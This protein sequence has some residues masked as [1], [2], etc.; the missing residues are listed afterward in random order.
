MIVQS[1]ANIL[2]A[3]ILDLLI[4]SGRPSWR[5]IESHIHAVVSTGADVRPFRAM[6]VLRHEPCCRCGGNVR[7]RRFRLSVVLLDPEKSRVRVCLCSVLARST[8]DLCRFDVVLTTYGT[9]SSELL[10][11]EADSRAVAN[12]ES[13]YA[14]AVGGAVP[15]Y[16]P[17]ALG[18]V[19]RHCGYVA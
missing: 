18:A 11:N 14:R 2:L 8:R 6:Y 17:W 7:R 12:V 13:G 5:A 4:H 9:L 15:S 16:A 19:D 10:K 3:F 1:A